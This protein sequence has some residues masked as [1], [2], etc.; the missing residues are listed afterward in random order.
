M[1]VCVCVCVAGVLSVCTYQGLTLLFAPCHKLNHTR[2]LQLPAL[3]RHTNLLHGTEPRAA[4][5][6]HHGVF[7]VCRH[8]VRLG[9]TFIYFNL[10]GTPCCI[11]RGKRGAQRKCL[12]QNPNTVQ[13]SAHPTQTSPQLSGGTINTGLLINTEF[14]NEAAQPFLLGGEP[15]TGATHTQ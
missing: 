13:T 3:I 11:V 10:V 4:S 8:L 7:E 14:A 2:N 6:E 9:Y 12:T 1:C 15:H 5:G